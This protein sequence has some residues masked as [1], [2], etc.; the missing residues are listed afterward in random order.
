MSNSNRKTNTTT[1]QTY[2]SLRGKAILLNSLILSKVTCLS[3]VFPIPKTL[4]LKI[5]DIILKHKWQ[6]HKTDP[7]AR[8][9][10][11]LPKYQGGIELI[12]PQHHSLAMWLKHLLKLKLKT[13]QKTW[14]ILTRYNLTSILYHLHKDLKY[15]ILNNAIKS[16]KPNINFYYED[17]I[18]YLKKQ[19][20]VLEL[21][22][23]SW[24]FYK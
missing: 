23:N 8:K 11:F 13:N 2:L 21:S 18:N 10:L 16:E 7:V 14:I 6:F 15:M 24:K 17:I 22:K 3:N 19:N 12:Y 20:T 4:Q 1:F 5:E 9:S